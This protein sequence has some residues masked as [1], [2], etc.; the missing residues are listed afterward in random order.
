MPS[1]YAPEQIIEAA[2]RRVQV[3]DGYIQER[4]DAV[5]H[6]EALIAGHRRAIVS[7][8]NERA[9]AARFL[10]EHGRA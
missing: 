3:I 2:R 6:M 7:W 1:P 4:E 8:R 10:R 5:R 9:E